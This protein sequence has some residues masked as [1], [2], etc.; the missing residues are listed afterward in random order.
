MKTN[1][2]PFGPGYDPAEALEI[3][4]LAAAV[5][6][7]VPRYNTDHKFSELDP[8]APATSSPI[9]A[10]LPYSSPGPIMPSLFPDRW[11]TGWVAGL[12]TGDNPTWERSIVVSYGDGNLSFANQAFLTYNPAADAYCLAF[13]GTITPG[14]VL[15]D[16][17]CFLVPAGP[18]TVGD[19]T[20]PVLAGEENAP[21]PKHPAVV[22]HFIEK[23][24]VSNRWYCPSNIP[25]VSERACVHGGFRVALESLDFAAVSPV[26]PTNLLERVENVLERKEHTLTGLLEEI[27]RRAAGRP[28]KLYV[29]GHSLG[30]GMAS[31]CAAWLQ[32]Q[33]IKNAEFRVKLYAFAQPKPGNDYFAS[34]QGIAFGPGWI[35]AVVNS[36]D[37][38]PQVGLTLQNL[39]ALNYQGCIEFLASKLGPIAW[40]AKNLI[41]PFNFVHMGS[42]IYL[43]GGPIAA[44]A[45]PATDGFYN[46]PQVPSPDPAPSAATA[47]TE[48]EKQKSG[49]HLPT[50]GKK[51][52]PPAPN[53]GP[54]PPEPVFKFPAYL[55]LPATPGMPNDYVPPAD[56]WTITPYADEDAATLG[57]FAP[58][59]Q[60][61][62]WI[63][64]QALVQQIARLKAS[65]DS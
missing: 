51:P 24:K 27:G 59:W 11:P 53:P 63:Y 22:A 15:E 48:A 40:I 38:I 6:A 43:E 7:F 54:K 1:L 50:L 41:P 12:W 36:L 16:L 55:F 10:T 29:T 64:Q 30:A 19:F 34:A 52:T 31:L 61:M 13:R 26:A 8:T 33:P 58:L 42:E 14:N 44:G 56:T 65:N 28:I 17:G 2:P 37:T 25:G 32:T 3:L 35:Y 47:A 4:R 62:P 49:L 57:M 20:P 45:T 23:V 46:L 21:P 60:H 9:V 18:L 5:S 39:K